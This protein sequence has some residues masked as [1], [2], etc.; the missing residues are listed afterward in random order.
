MSRSVIGYLLAQG[1]VDV[2]ALRCQCPSPP[3][4]RRFLSG[5]LPANPTSQTALSSPP[6]AA[7]T[8]CVIC[9][10]GGRRYKFDSILQIGHRFLFALTDPARVVDRS[11]RGRVRRL[12]RSSHS[13]WVCQFPR[14]SVGNA[15]PSLPNLTL[16]ITS[17]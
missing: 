7:L 8:T 10:S 12:R 5:P 4:W 15:L 1:G 6:S 9:C 17:F 16:F 3:T 11:I 2:L 13:R 14:Q